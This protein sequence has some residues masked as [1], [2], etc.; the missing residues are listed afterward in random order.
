MSDHVRA[1]SWSKRKVLQQSKAL[2]FKTLC[3]PGPAQNYGLVR[4]PDRDPVQV[5]P[6][7]RSLQL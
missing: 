5:R 2:G 4:V 7:N 3:G 6:G 1:H